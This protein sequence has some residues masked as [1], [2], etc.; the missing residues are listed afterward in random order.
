M[1]VN[2]E[3]VTTT[4]QPHAS[5]YAGFNQFKFA[6]N[7]RV[8][9]GHAANLTEVMQSQDENQRFPLHFASKS[10]LDQAVKIAEL[11][12]ANGG[13]ANWGDAN[14][15][16]PLHFAAAREGY[17]ALC[18]TMIARGGNVNQGDQDGFTPFH[19]ACYS[20][21]VA[22]VQAIY[23]H[24]NLQQGD[25][26]G[27]NSLHY[28]VIGGNAHVVEHLLQDS[29]PYMYNIETLSLKGNSVGITPLHLAAQNNSEA[30][31][32]LFRG[33]CDPNQGDE[34]AFTA[35]HR[36]T[37][38]NHQAAVFSLLD[39]GA[40]PL[41]GN[42]AGWSPIHIAAESGFHGILNE[43]H[44]RKFDLSAGNN[45]GVT[46]L[47]IAC[48][49]GHLNASHV[50]LKNNADIIN[51]QNRDGYSPLDYA[52][53]TTNQALVAMMLNRGAEVTVRSLRQSLESNIEITKL[54]L[55]RDAIPSQD[56]VTAAVTHGFD[57]VN[58]LLR[59]G[60]GATEE[61]LKVAAK[62]E[63]AQNLV[64]LLVE[65]GATITE[66]V[67]NESRDEYKDYLKTHVG[68]VFT[69]EFQDPGIPEYNLLGLYEGHLDP[70]LG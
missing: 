2:L 15:H 51:Q 30:L 26:Q 40:D 16:T 49:N 38:A 14:S 50:L 52:C 8:G 62:V 48:M 31:I 25:N 47:H 56:D 70:T 59:C 58:L 54:I 67:I 4:T 28:A 23:Q 5:A 37:A 12:L 66:D 18:Q 33:K 36:A 41:Q 9:K 46:P 7:Q 13:N 29:A 35:L 39:I 57:I 20:G 1:L 53:T 24:A 22:T 19:G 3:L 68:E 17:A 27:R 42:T 65:Y 60:G 69:P 44:I 32:L 61:A 63:N 34:K 21:G 6:A 45:I 10:P 11:A 43:M 64:K 55:S